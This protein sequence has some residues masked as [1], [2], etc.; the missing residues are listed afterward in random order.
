MTTHGTTWGWRALLLLLGIGL[1][2]CFEVRNG[3]DYDDDTV[4]DDSW[5]DDDGGDDDA[6]DDDGGDD[7]D[8]AGCYLEQTLDGVPAASPCP[9]C[10]YTFDV[11]YTTVD[12]DG[13]CTLGPPFADGVHTLAFDSDWTYL[14]SGPYEVILIDDNGWRFW[15]RA[16]S[17]QGGHSLEFS[18]QGNG[19]T[20][21]GYWD[22]AGEGAAMTGLAINTEP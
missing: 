6:G 13:S 3:P 15:Y 14:S 17:G 9:D 2:G 11:T 20:M 18:Y 5:G 1:L 4:D 12:S 8:G 22:I 16:Y 10:D 21:S 7:D 19:Y